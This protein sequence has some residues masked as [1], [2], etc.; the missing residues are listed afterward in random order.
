MT[1]S[2]RYRL[3][4]CFP[5]SWQKRRAKSIQSEPS[6][7]RR[8]VSSTTEQLP[9]VLRARL[10][11]KSIL[12]SQHPAP[13][14]LGPPDSRTQTFQLHNL[15]VVHEQVDFRPVI[16]DVPAEHLGI[17]CF[18]HDLV[19]AQGVCETARCAGAPGCDVLRNA[20]RLDHD[21]I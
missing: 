7:Q 11:R 9:P 4:K 13:E 2:C 18:K 14:I 21:E 6:T 3:L 10:E 1:R 8:G 20:F 16:L 15:A 12:I 5:T 17:S 19:L